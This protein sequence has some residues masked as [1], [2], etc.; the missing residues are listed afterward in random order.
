MWEQVF[1]TPLDRDL[2]EEEKKQKED[3]LQKVKGEWIK[4]TKKKKWT[5]DDNNQM[6]EKYKT[7][8]KEKTREF[9]LSSFSEIDSIDPYIRF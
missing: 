6:V 7:T 8:L 4:R 3:E 9:I 2:T 5:D 1:T